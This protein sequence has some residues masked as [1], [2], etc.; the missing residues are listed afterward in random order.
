MLKKNAVFK[1]IVWIIILCLFLTATACGGKTE[2]PTDN[3]SNDGEFAS[4]PTDDNDDD[5]IVNNNADNS[6]NEYGVTNE[7]NSSNQTGNNVNNT[8]ILFN[9]TASTSREGYL[10]SIPS[11]FEGK[12]V[13][14]L[15]WREWYDWEAAKFEDLTRETGIKVK[16]IIVGDPD[17]G[18]YYEKL[19]ALIMQ[20][21]TPDL[22]C[23]SSS[24]LPELITQNYFQPLS[25]ANFEITD[26]I[27]DVKLMH[28]YRHNGEYYGAAF[29]NSPVTS[30]ISVVY[31]NNDL[32]EQLGVTPPHLL[33]KNDVDWNW[34]AFLNTALEL[35]SK[36]SYKKQINLAVDVHSFILSTGEDVISYNKGVVTNNFKSKKVYDA[37]KFF[38]ELRTKHGLVI[39]EGLES[40][41]NGESALCIAD[42][43]YAL[44]GGYFDK[45]INERFDWRFFYFPRQEGYEWN[46]PT[47]VKMF[48]IPK[49]AEPITAGIVLRYWLDSNFDPPGSGICIQENKLSLNF[50]DGYKGHAYSYGVLDYGINSN[51][52]SNY[53]QMVK[54]LNDADPD[55]FASILS[56]FSN[57][58]DK[59]IKKIQNDF[60]N[61]DN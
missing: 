1:L 24:H 11:S 19:K 38:A 36:S 41:C 43:S 53:K 9:P 17:N 40:F 2:N 25:A 30:T 12:T 32:F 55:S 21:S 28:R 47:F 58:A 50:S 52:E 56:E 48:G 57:I 4:I 39:T 14:I 42:S 13:E 46:A 61:M 59:N 23:L 34:E 8:D 26:E 22:A 16:P 20:K 15:I 51:S 45:N 44:S 10:S 7:N 33:Y 29:K 3:S 60:A 54:R 37:C 5:V 6:Q 27:F 35:Q 18:D 49:T 31:Y